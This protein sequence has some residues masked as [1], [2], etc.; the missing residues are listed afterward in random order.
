MVALGK[1]APENARAIDPDPEN[2]QKAAPRPGF[3][4]G[5]EVGPAAGRSGGTVLAEETL[6]GTTRQGQHGTVAQ[7]PLGTD[8][9]AG[10]VTVVA[11]ARW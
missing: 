11:G 3:E 10:L 8:R 9:S 6:A 4:T 2:C 5:R 1:T 7:V